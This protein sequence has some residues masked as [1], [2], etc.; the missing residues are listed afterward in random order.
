MKKLELFNF[1][2]ILSSSRSR[3]S[4]FGAAAA[5][6]AL[7]LSGCGS[8]YEGIQYPEG[9]A[10]LGLQPNADIAYGVY[11]AYEFEGPTKLIDQ[12]DCGVENGNSPSTIIVSQASGQSEAYCIAGDGT[13]VD[14]EYTQ[15]AVK[16]Y[17]AIPPQMIK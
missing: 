4:L 11:E 3:R 6:L 9:V 5:G 10:N 14:N 16:Q 17:L 12:V 8:A 7:F 13:S 2:D 1:S 15:K